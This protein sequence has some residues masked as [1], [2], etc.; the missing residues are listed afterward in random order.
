MKY[1]GLRLRWD[2]LRF[3]LMRQSYPP[4]ASNAGSGETRPIPKDAP[5]HKHRD[6]RTRR[7]RDS[8]RE[9]PRGGANGGSQS[10]TGA[11]GAASGGNRNS[12]EPREP[13]ACPGSAVGPVSLPVAGSWVVPASWTPGFAPGVGG[14]TTLAAAASARGRKSTD[15]IRHTARVT[16]RGSAAGPVAGSAASRRI[17]AWWPAR[18]RL[19]VHPQRAAA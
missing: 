1:N 11:Q 6:R 15:R 14:K 17:A 9:K 2:P 5:N 16:R 8:R 13:R 18:A 19:P 3:W 12:L 4:V 10:L 7:R